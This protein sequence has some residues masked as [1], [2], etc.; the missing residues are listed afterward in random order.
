MANRFSFDLV[1]NDSV[2]VNKYSNASGIGD[3]FLE[4]CK[5]I[6]E[7]SEFPN[8]DCSIEEYVSGGIF[9]S[10]EKTRMLELSFTKSKF[11]QLGVFFRAQQFG[12]IVVF[13]KYET[14]EKDVFDLITGKTND[15]V[16]SG[17]RSS[18]SNIAQFEEYLGLVHLGSLVFSDALI[19]I[20]PDYE[21]RQKLHEM[22]KGQVN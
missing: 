14:L 12:N 3:K 16:R 8:I 17:I 4:T 9:F 21:K 2:Y 6:V 22:E 5:K 13:S 19:S 11:K 10:K 7:Q 20:D 15:Q 18:C 1:Y